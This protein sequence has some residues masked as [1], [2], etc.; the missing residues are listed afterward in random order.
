MIG[1]IPAHPPVPPDENARGDGAPCLH[2]PERAGLP[3]ECPLAWAQPLQPAAVS[4]LPPSQACFHR[5]RRA[6][7]V[8]WRGWRAVQTGSGRRPPVLSAWEALAK[9]HPKTFLWLNSLV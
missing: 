2:S 3:A 6:V 5:L 4:T 1:S 9:Q 8:A 7:R